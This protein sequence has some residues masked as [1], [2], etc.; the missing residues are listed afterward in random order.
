MFLLVSQSVHYLQSYYYKHAATNFNLLTR[1]Y[2]DATNHLTRSAWTQEERLRLTEAVQQHK[3][4][5]Y[6]KWTL[7]ASHVKTRD[8]VQ[9]YHKWNRYLNPMYRRGRWTRDEDSALFDALKLFGFGNWTKI[10]RHIGSRTPQ[11]VRARAHLMSQNSG[12]AFGAWNDEEI[13]ALKKACSSFTEQELAVFKYDVW[14]KISQSVITRNPVQC[15]SKY[16]RLVNAKL[17]WNSKPWTIDEDRRLV[18][19]V[20]KYGR[21]WK[22][23]TTF[24]FTNRTPIQLQNRYRTVKVI[25]EM[26]NLKL[27]AK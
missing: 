12:H 27:N 17:T 13:A 4:S 8:Y 15:R 26:Q 3:D 24:C 20:E 14:H 6:G 23:L 2:S 16:E 7:I 22:S 25:S 10:A 18:E 9:C 1:K 11:Q 21:K 19:A 5:S